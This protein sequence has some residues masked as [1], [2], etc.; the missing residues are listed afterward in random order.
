MNKIFTHDFPEAK[1][2]HIRFGI[3]LKD[4]QGE[5]F[6]LNFGSETAEKLKYLLSNFEFRVPKNAEGTNE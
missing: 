5:E 6:E 2:Q 3:R 1:G 4:K